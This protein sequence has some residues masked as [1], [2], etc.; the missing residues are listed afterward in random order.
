MW[1]QSHGTLYLTVNKKIA[2]EAHVSTPSDFMEK[3]LIICLKAAKLQVKQHKLQTERK[4]HIPRPTKHL[5]RVILTE[6]GGL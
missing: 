2:V 6:N 5:L 4:V 1:N 3:M